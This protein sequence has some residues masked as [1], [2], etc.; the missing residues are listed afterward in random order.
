MGMTLRKA[1]PLMMAVHRLQAATRDGYEDAEA[2]AQAVRDGE[3]VRNHTLAELLE[4]NRAMR[5]ARR[6]EAAELPEHLIAAAYLA[7]VAAPGKLSVVPTSVDDTAGEPTAHAHVVL[8]VDA[9][10]GEMLEAGD[11]A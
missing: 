5:Q 6:T 11:D 7:A 10:M 8:V 2:V 3:L 4:A 1:A 9:G